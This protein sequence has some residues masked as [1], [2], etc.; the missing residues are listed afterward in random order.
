MSSTTREM[1]RYQYERKSRN[2]EQCRGTT[3][4]HTIKTISTPRP[5][6]NETKTV[7]GD[8]RVRYASSDYHVHQQLQLEVHHTKG[9][10]TKT[11]EIVF[12]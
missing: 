8:N 9:G 7:K 3:K 5:A 10:R 4:N 11:I 2:P 1:K 12:R 6:S